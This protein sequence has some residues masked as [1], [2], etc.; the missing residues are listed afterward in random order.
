M[1]SHTS[2][3]WLWL[4]AVVMV[5]ASACSD[6]KCNDYS[7]YRRVPS[8][9]WRYADS[10]KFIPLHAD[11]LC[12]GRFVVG[13]THDDSYRFTEL[14][15]EVTHFSGSSLRRDTL[16]M[17]VVDRFGTWTGSGIGSSFQLADT[18]PVGVHPSGN[19]V[20]VRHIMRTDTLPGVNK[21]GLF[22]VPDR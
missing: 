7:E 15:M 2:L 13:I 17:Q 5:V 1:R 11:S 22:F 10:V 4:T 3:I 14:C 6:Y 12:K 20:V 18:L 19:M 16:R 9:G 8:V 21:V